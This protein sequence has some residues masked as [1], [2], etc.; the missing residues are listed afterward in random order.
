[1]K[2]LILIFVLINICFAQQ[3]SILYDYIVDDGYMLEFHYKPLYEYDST[4][5]IDSLD[6]SVIYHFDSIEFE[7]I[8][9]EHNDNA[10]FSNA[11]YGMLINN[12][13]IDSVHIQSG[14]VN[15]AL[16]S[17][18]EEE[19]NGYLSI[20]GEKLIDLKLDSSINNKFYIEFDTLKTDTNYLFNFYDIKDRYML[21]STI[22]HF[23]IK[24]NLFFIGR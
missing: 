9:L 19:S 14:K 6:T 16:N 12:D 20:N 21:L 1:L 24:N 4:V 23:I 2:Y 18:F 7:I 8:E 17:F 22:R 15:L 5:Y 10:I 3:D 11:D 13:F